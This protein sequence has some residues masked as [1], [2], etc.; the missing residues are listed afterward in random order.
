MEV[1]TSVGA[2]LPGSGFSF[3]TLFY[4]PGASY[5]LFAGA[6]SEAMPELLSKH[7]RARLGRRRQTL[8][9]PFTSPS[10]N[11]T[12]SVLQRFIVL[13]I[14]CIAVDR[15]LPERVFSCEKAECKYVALFELVD[16]AFL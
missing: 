6:A 14:F 8:V 13:P 12:S 10:S 15:E 2:A 4:L 5:Y 1:V 16:L 11:F 9:C 7:P 3:F